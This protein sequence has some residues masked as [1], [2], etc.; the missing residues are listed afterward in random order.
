MLVLEDQEETAS[1][2]DLQ[3]HCTLYEE[4]VPTKK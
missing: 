1:K 2:T 4:A 3:H